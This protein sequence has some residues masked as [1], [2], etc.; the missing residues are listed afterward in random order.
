MT[1]EIELLKSVC[2]RLEEAGTP[3]MLTGSLAAHFYAVPRMTRDIDIVIEMMNLEVNKVFRIFQDDF[4]VS[5][6]SIVDAI[7][8]ET[9]FNVI[10]NQSGFKVDFIIR[11][12][13]PYRSVEFQRRRQIEFDGVK[14]WIVSSEDLI[15]SKLYWAKDSFSEL[16]INDV[17]NLMRSIPKLDV[18]YIE[19]WV[20]G[21]NL[22]DVYAKVRSL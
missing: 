15:I 5:K 21:L 2:R 4:Y 18:K 1:Q 3:Y 14:I 6:D 19:K 20:L 17:R 13:I 12:D 7:K 11:K 8:F 16:Q 22:N 9:M 10:H